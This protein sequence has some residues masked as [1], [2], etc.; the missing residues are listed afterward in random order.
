MSTFRLITDFWKSRYGSDLPEDVEVH[1]LAI[2]VLKTIAAEGRDDPETIAWVAEQLLHVNIEFAHSGELPML[3]EFRRLKSSGWERETAVQELL[4]R[5]SRVMAA[6][7]ARIFRR[8]LD[9]LKE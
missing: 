3:E 2:Q 8:L 4:S 9:E 1:L 7:N 6:Y 5:Q